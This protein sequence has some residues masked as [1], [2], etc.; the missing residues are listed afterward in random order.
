MINPEHLRIPVGMSIVTHFGRPN[1]NIATVT[2]IYRIPVTADVIRR[3]VDRELFC[4]E[5]GIV[6]DPDGVSFS[7][8]KE[9]GIVVVEALPK[10]SAEDV[11]AEFE[12]KILGSRQGVSVTQEE[13]GFTFVAGSG[14][15]EKEDNV[16]GLLREFVIV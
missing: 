10:K 16:T 14:K 4:Q 3:I 9:T 1:H 6:D 8:R 13:H 15:F 2:G 7:V 12:D 5:D 11:N